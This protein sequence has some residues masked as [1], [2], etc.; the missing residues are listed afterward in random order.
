MSNR[1]EAKVVIV[2]GSSTGIGQA[3]AVSFGQEGA[4]LVIHG[5]DYETEELKKTENLLKEAGVPA[6]HILK[7]FGQMEDQATQE[8]IVNETIKKFGRIDVLVNNAGTAFCP[9]VSNQDELE[10]LDFIYRVNF[11]SVV[12][13]TQFAL[14]HLEKTKGCVVNVSSMSSTFTAQ[15][16]THYCSMKA[17]LDMFTRCYADK[18]GA[19]GVRI[20]SVNPGFIRTNIVKRMGGDQEK[21]EAYASE[22]SS[23][24]RIG[25]PSEM[26]NVIKFLASP[27]ASYVTGSNWKAD[28]GTT[29]YNTQGLNEYSYGIKHS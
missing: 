5:Q 18:Y 4:L 8:K 25:Q 11:R 28:G 19:K 7:L 13:L 29:C 21:M 24:K 14:P 2:T 9:N 26:A 17:A 16:I 3:T 1:F 27:E 23:L 6:D 10:A 22:F 12:A 20:N 15:T